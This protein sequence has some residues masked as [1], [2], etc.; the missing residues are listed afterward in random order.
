MI[1]QSKDDKHNI[2]K[3]LIGRGANQSEHI[4]V[5]KKTDSERFSRWSDST[6]RLT[7]K[8]LNEL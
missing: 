5:K 8:N 3:T 4:E 2:I 7:I 1:R 6:R